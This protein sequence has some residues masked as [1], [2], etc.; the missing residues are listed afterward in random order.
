MTTGYGAACRS[1]W[2]LGCSDP[3]VASPGLDRDQVPTIEAAD[4][5]TL[6]RASDDTPSADG[7]EPRMG[8]EPSPAG[9]ETIVWSVGAGDLVY[10]GPRH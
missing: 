6:A 1:A 3:G 2:R 8:D 7:E 9:W 4:A 5:W 10:P